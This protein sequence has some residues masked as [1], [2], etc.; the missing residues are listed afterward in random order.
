MTFQ[1]PWMLLTLGLVPLLVLAYFL[2]QRQR[3]AYTLKFTNMALLNK[4]AGRR[5]GWRRHLPPLFFLLSL[6]VLLVSL[7]RPTA[8]IATPKDQS[9]I[10]IVMD[11]SGS[12]AANDLQPTR[13]DA[14]K[15][16]A[17]DFVNALPSNARVGLISFNTAARVDAPLTTDR[18]VITRAI[19]NLNY[20]GGT[21]IG[22]GL[23]AAIRQIALQTDQPAPSDSNTPATP[24]PGIVV[25]LS[26]GKSNAG[27]SPEQATLQAKSANVKVYTV[28]IGQR[29]SMPT[30]NGRF[31]PDLVLDETTLQDIASQTGGQYYYAAETGEL[32]NIYT[33]I[34]SQISWVT[35]E[36]EITALVSALGTLLMLVA[37]GLSLRWFHQ[38]S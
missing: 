20:G 13:L 9:N 32:R 36:T 29:G 31:N 22:E 7:A 10:M 38:L 1:W 8:V 35:E 6:V 14:A 12:M 37:G 27:L 16:A 4:V 33:G 23:S 21:A 19:Q 26:D 30:L 3:R 18:K 25:L 11:V 24:V 2:V 17:Q 28:G 15:Q 5:P 34:S